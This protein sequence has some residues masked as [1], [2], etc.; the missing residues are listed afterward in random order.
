[1]WLALYVANGSA[2]R[3]YVFSFKGN[4]DLNVNTGAEQVLFWCGFNAI[5]GRRYRPTADIEFYQKSGTPAVNMALHLRIIAG[6]TPT[7]TAGTILRGKYPNTPS[8]ALFLTAPM[9][10]LGDDWVAPTTGTYAVSVSGKVDA[11]QGGIAGSGA[12]T[13]HTYGILIEDIGL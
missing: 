7:A 11:G 6:A 8:G 9:T 5:G 13:D 12:N 4:A 3:G 10:M 1:V 2:P